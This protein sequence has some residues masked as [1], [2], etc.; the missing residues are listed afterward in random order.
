MEGSAKFIRLPFFSIDVYIDV[1]IDHA[2]LGARES[3]QS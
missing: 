1:S 2:D 3:V